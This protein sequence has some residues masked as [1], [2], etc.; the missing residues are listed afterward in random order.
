MTYVFRSKDRSVDLGNKV[1][2]E[3]YEFITNDDELAALV[4]RNIKAQPSSFWEATPEVLEE[5]KLPPPKPKGKHVPVVKTG[6]RDSTVFE[7][8]ED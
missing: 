6:A 1:H 5:M 3:N 7:G 8:K 2:F 4:R